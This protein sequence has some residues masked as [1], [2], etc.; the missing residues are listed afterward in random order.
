M[1]IRVGQRLVVYVPEEKLAQ[2]KSK[3]A[4]AGKVDNTAPVP[5][6]ELAEGEYTLYTIKSGDN[7]WDIA[8]KYPGIT[9]RDIMRWN[10]LSDADV[11]RL[12]PGQQLKIK[13]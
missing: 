2:Y 13:I 6:E 7:L 11:K 3:A 10:G 1:T 4:Y 5:R 12:K 9:N 8:K